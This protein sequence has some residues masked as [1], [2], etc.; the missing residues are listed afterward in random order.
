MASITF[1]GRYPTLYSYPKYYPSYP[2]PSYLN[3]YS[4]VS[5]GGYLRGAN[6][7]V[8]RGTAVLL[9]TNQLQTFANAIRQHLATGSTNV[10]VNGVQVVTSGAGV[11]I[12][13][14]GNTLNLPNNDA[15][16][17]ASRV[18]RY[19]VTGAEPQDTGQ[20]APMNSYD[21]NA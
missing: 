15:A 3:V 20:G 2:P 12:T 16:E 13:V 6:L 1:G 10:T 5:T 21:L 14:S 11:N 18:L 8:S 9:T 19:T 7:I 17:L 4:F